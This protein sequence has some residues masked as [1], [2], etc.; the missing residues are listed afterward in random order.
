[1]NVLK[2]SQTSFTQIQRH[3][4]AP[5]QCVFQ[6]M[7]MAVYDTIAAG[8]AEGTQKLAQSSKHLSNRAL[9]GLAWVIIVFDCP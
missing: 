5:F 4:S 1:M 2:A 9:P 7:W 8:H 6:R 3:S